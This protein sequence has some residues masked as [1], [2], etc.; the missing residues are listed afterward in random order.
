MIFFELVDRQ[1][2]IMSAVEEDALWAAYQLDR[3]SLKLKSTLKLLED[4]FTEERLE[5]AKLRFDILYSRIHVLEAGELHVLFKRLPEYESLLLFL[6]EKML[7][8]ERL[9]FNEGNATIVADILI[10][11]DEMLKETESI[12]HKTLA[13]RSVEKVQQRKDALGL[14]IELG[15]LIALLTPEFKSEVRHFHFKQLST[16]L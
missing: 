10:K 5:E 16:F 4:E 15:S 1:K 13:S 11:S 7:E 2:V 14:F 3:E 12:V 8:I 6:Q 9:L